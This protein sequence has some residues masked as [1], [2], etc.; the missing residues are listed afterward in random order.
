MG[1]SELQFFPEIPPKIKE[2][3]D[4]KRKANEQNTPPPS[5][6]SYHSECSYVLYLPFFLLCAMAG[7]VVDP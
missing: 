6:A 7:S 3:L 2:T 4:L 1:F 5:R